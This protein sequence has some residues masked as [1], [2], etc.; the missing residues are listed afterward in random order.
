MISLS[1]QYGED[2]QEMMEILTMFSSPGRRD[3]EI[4]NLGR[5]KTGAE[6]AVQGAEQAADHA[7]QA[8]P[9]WREMALQAVRE[10]IKQHQGVFQA[11]DVRTY[12]KAVPPAPSLRAWGSVM[13]TASRIGLIRNTGQTAKVSNPVAHMANS[14]LWEIV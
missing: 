6:L 4:I 11:E 8:A 5:R 9:G 13:L 10:F 1:R 7:E 12:A 14:A 3:A 2:S